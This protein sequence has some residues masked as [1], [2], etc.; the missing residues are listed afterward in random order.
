MEQAR[1]TNLEDCSKILDVFQNHDHNE[2][3]TARVYGG[4]S[5]EE[6]LGQ[7]KWQ[8]RG[9]IMDTKLAPTG[10]RN[11]KAQLAQD[12]LRLYTHDPKELKDA[13]LDSLKAL[14]T[15][16]VSCTLNERSEI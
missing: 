8:E 1:V 4:G 12:G 14:Q 9:I 15:D 16:K 10:T 6:Y 11:L 13:L 2:I 3:D 5:S 7:L